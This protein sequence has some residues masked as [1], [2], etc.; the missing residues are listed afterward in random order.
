MA[1]PS[2]DSS[3]QVGPS[4]PLT[5]DLRTPILH[6]QVFYCAVLDGCSSI[7]LALSAAAPFADQ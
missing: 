4:K 1:S 6:D 2:C 7:F 3:A 5:S